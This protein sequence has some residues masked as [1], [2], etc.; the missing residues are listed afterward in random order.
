MVL[1]KMLN[2]TQHSLIAFIRCLLKIFHPLTG[3]FWQINQLLSPVLEAAQ[4]LQ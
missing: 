2:A 4:H 3:R 1:D